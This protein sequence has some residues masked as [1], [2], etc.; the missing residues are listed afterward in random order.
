MVLKIIDG[1]KYNHAEAIT[2]DWEDVGVIVMQESS[3]SITVSRIDGRMWLME[4]DPE[5]E[6][7]NPHYSKVEELDR[8]GWNDFQYDLIRMAQGYL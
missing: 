7:H 2:Q 3:R 4:Y 5:W 6:D 8:D 1:V